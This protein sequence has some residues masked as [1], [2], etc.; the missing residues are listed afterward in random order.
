MPPANPPAAPQT[1]PAV[2]PPASDQGLPTWFAVAVPL[3]IFGAVAGVIFLATLIPFG[4]KKEE[5]KGADRRSARAKPRPAAPVAPSARLHGNRRGNR[6]AD[7]E[8]EV[9]ELR[10][11]DIIPTPAPEEEPLLDALPVELEPHQEAP[12]GI[13]DALPADAK[14]PRLEL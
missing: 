1:R 5:A 4:R 8:L 7:D 11:E 3:A 9:L 14:W 13:A 12:V 6:Q 2:P 10:E